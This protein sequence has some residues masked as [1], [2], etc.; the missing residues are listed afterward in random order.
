[1]ASI[2]IT[3]GA[4]F[5]G[6][7][8]AEAL[9]K[10]HEV[11]ILD[12][13]STGKASNVPKHKRVK[14]VRGDICDLKVVRD[15]VKGADHV[16]HLAAIASVPRSMKDPEETNRVNAGG[17]FNLLFESAR[18]E[19]DR[20]VYA[21][22]SA[23]YGDLPGL[24]K[25]EG[26]EL[27]PISP[28]AA[29]KLAGERFCL[30]F[31]RNF[32]L[33]TVSFRY[34]NIYGP[35][36][37]PKSEYAAVIPKFIELMEEGKRPVIYG[38]GEQTRDFTYVGDVIR[39]NEIALEKKK[40]AGDVFNIAS[41]KRTS[42]NELVEKLNAVLGTKLK[43]AYEKERPGDVLHSYADVGKA[44]RVLGFK[45]EWSMEEGLKETLKDF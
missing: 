9:C 16:I 6:S 30:V 37:D 39:A 27:S 36:Q 18:A 3:G 31:E 10:E 35:R 20:F 38:N 5:I 44:K 32:G 26:S 7:N 12:N 33:S 1:M 2:L 4:G 11:V 25:R 22:T 42:I 40:G 24:P 41:G 23:V 15:A 34:F 19:V 13:L 17:T 43:P 14:F 8:L 45:A 28:Y 29:T 21:S